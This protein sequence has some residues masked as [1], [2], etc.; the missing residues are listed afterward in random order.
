VLTDHDGKVIGAVL[1]FRNLAM[2]RRLEEQVRRSH[3]LAALGQMAAGVAHEVRNPLNSIRGFAQLLQ[4]KTN[5]DAS[6]AEYTQIILE[7][8]DRMNRIVTDLLDFSR[9]RELT[10]VPVQIEK[11]IE[12]LVREMQADA[13]RGNVELK[14][15]PAATVLPDILGNGDKLRQVFRN[16]ILNAIQACDKNG[17]VTLRL[18]LVADTLPPRKD[19]EPDTL[20]R[21]QVAVEITDSGCGM[22]SKTIDKIF[23]PFFTQKDTGTGLGLSISQKIVDQHGGRIDVKSEPGK[24]STFTIILPAL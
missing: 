17:K 7:E 3:H 2:I 6:C 8:V 10:L 18:A 22:D 13:Q 24:G 15:V 21:R 14:T 20:L 19:A 16:I 12:D 11:L 1:N 5:Q 4:E 9:Q 23:D